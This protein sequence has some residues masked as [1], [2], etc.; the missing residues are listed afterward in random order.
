M[1]LMG[2]RY[3][4]HDRGGGKTCV[5]YGAGL[6]STLVLRRMTF[7]KDDELYDFHLI[8]LIDDD[9]NLWRK[10]IHGYRVLGGVD[11]LCELMETGGVDEVIISCT[12]HADALQRVKEVARASGVGVER[13]SYVTQALV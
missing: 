1:D 7:E 3:R 10:M 12:I 2:W 5:I 6:Q 9:I 13:W 4:R 11:Q 8:G